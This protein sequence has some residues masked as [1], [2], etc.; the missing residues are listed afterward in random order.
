MDISNSLV[1]LRKKTGLKQIHAAATIGISQTYLSQIEAG[2]KEP[3]TELL[4]RICKV[5][6]IPASVMYFMA[7]TVDDVPKKKQRI[8]LELKPVIDNLI[9]QFI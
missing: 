7:M 8:F 6:D 1:S 2:K 4:Q 9:S 3:S 5:Y